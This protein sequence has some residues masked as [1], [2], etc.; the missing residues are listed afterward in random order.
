MACLKGNIIKTLKWAVA[1]RSGQG[2]VGTTKKALKE[3]F[4]MILNDG[5]MLSYIY[6]ELEIVKHRW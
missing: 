3:L 4:C 1:I 2:K 6:Q 5:F